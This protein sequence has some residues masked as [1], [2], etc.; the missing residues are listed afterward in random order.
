MKISYFVFFLHELDQLCLQ[1][2]RYKLFPNGTLRINTVEVYDNH[3]YTCQSQT[4]G[5][6]L[7]ARARVFVLGKT[8]QMRVFRCS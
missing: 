6:R 8:D 2:V 1:D 5:G 3:M 7:E 4:E